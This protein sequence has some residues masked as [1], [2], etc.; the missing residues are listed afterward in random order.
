MINRDCAYD[1][2]KAY[3]QA[4]SGITYNSQAVNVYDEIVPSGDNEEPIL[5]IDAPMEFAIWFPAVAVTTP[6]SCI[7]FCN[8]CNFSFMSAMSAEKITLCSL[9]F[10]AITLMN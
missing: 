5:A 10:S 4:L 2:R 9:T 3:F 7:A 6:A 8:S 1:L